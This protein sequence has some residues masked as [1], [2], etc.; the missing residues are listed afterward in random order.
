ML[1]YVSEIRVTIEL[2]LTIGTLWWTIRAFVVMSALRDHLM[3]EEDDA[4][5]HLDGLNSSL[6]KMEDTASKIRD[7]I[8]PSQMNVMSQLVKQIDTMEKN[9]IKSGIGDKVRLFKEVKKFYTEQPDSRYFRA[10]DY[11][12]SGGDKP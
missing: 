10:S 5:S 2:I 4:H 3:R 12:P 11:T 8:I 9:L 6:K 1:Q 7:K